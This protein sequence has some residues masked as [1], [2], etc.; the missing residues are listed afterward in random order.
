MFDPITL[1]HLAIPTII[2]LS[3]SLLD[4]AAP[5]LRPS[6]LQPTSS[7]TLRLGDLSVTFV[8]NQAL[9]PD[10]RA[11]YNGIASLR[12]REEE[13]SPFVPL[14]AGFNLEHIFGGD[15]LQALFEPRKHP[16]ELYRM[17][18]KEVQLYQSPTPLSRMESL[19]TFTLVEPHYIDVTF[20]CR[21]MPSDFFKHGYAGIFWA[22][23]IQAPQDIRLHFR[24]SVSDDQ[25]EQWIAAYSPRHGEASTH[26]AA[27]DHEQIYFAENFNVTLASH[28][29]PHRFTE[30]YYYGRFGQM[31][32]AYFFDSDEIIRFSQ[33]PTG[34]GDKN[35]AWDFQYLIPDFDFDKVYT[36]RARMVYK[37]FVDPSDITQEFRS[38]SSGH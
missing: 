12:H 28:F 20:R 27:D 37:P 33:S 11:G 30:P 7:V 31:A 18:D 24:G 10:H 8:D 21:F 14:Y 22:S 25:E 9:P 29:S 38:W 6:G 13:A 26:L 2:L 32:L 15:S 5:V 19:T 36:F 35:P 1:R 34:G 16:M 17:S 23:Y 3:L 4:C